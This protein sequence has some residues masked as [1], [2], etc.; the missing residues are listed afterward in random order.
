M[1]PQDAK[2][3]R[4]ALKQLGDK[5]DDELDPEGIIWCDEIETRSPIEG[6]PKGKVQIVMYREGKPIAA[7]WGNAATLKRLRAEMKLWA[8]IKSGAYKAN[9]HGNT[10]G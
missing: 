7:M 10:P 3:M 2:K 4:H 9:H 1:L 8:H 6:M 5:V